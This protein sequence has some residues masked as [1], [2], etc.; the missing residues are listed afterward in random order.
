MIIRR[1]LVFILITPLFFIDILMTGIDI[2]AG[3]KPMYF[4]MTQDIEALYDG[5]PQ[6]LYIPEDG[7][8]R[9][10]VMRILADA[11]NMIQENEG[12]VLRPH[13]K[14]TDYKRYYPHVSEFLK[15]NQV[16][17]NSSQMYDVLSRAMLYAIPIGT[18]VKFGDVPPLPGDDWTKQQ[19]YW[20]SQMDPYLTS[21]FVPYS[22]D[23]YLMI[24]TPG[25]FDVH[26][27]FEP[28]DDF[29]D[30]VALQGQIPTPRKKGSKLKSNKK[31]KLVEA[32]YTWKETV[33]FDSLSK[34]EKKTVGKKNSDDT[35]VDRGQYAYLYSQSKSYG[36]ID[37]AYK[38]IVYVYRDN[39]FY[40][41]QAYRTFPNRDEWTKKIYKE[42]LQ[43][44]MDSYVYDRQNVIEV[45][46]HGRYTW[47]NQ[48][49][50]DHKDTSP[51]YKDRFKG[52]EDGVSFSVNI[53]IAD[54]ETFDLLSD[55]TE[56]EIDEWDDGSSSVV[57]NQFVTMRVLWEDY[58]QNNIDLIYDPNK[59]YTTLE[60]Y[61]EDVRY[62]L[63]SR[64][65]MPASYEM[66]RAL[67]D[68]ILN[69]T[70]GFEVGDTAISYYLP[71]G[72]YDN[73]HPEFFPEDWD[74]L[75]SEFG[76]V[77]KL[78]LFQYIFGN[79]IVQIVFWGVMLIS[80]ALCIGFS[81][82]A[83]MRSMGDF[84]LQKPVGRVF[85][86]ICKSM[87]TFLI[88][89]FFCIAT[90]QV[91]TAVLIQTTHI[92]ETAS[93]G[94]TSLSG[95]MF[96]T[97][98]RPRAVMMPSEKHP[99]VAFYVDQKGDLRQRTINAG[100]SARQE[101]FDTL[102]KEYTS[103]KKKVSLSTQ[104]QIFKDF[105][106][107]YAYHGDLFLVSIAAWFFLI[108]LALT[109]LIFLRRV[110]DVVTLYI[111]APLFVATIPL[112]DGQVFKRWREMF[113]GAAI[114]GFGSLITFKLFLLLMP[115]IFSPNLILDSNSAVDF[116]LKLLIMLGGMYAV[117]KMHSM[118]SQIA[119]PH[120]GQ[121]EA[122]GLMAGAAVLSF[123]KNAALA[124]STGGGSTA[125]Q[126]AKKK[127]LEAGKDKLSGGGD[128]KSSGN[129]NPDESGGSGG[130]G[131]ASESGGLPG[132]GGDDK[133]SG[134]DS[135]KNPNADSG[136]GGGLG[137][138]AGGGDSG[139]S[140]GD[141]NKQ[142]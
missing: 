46:D 3:V 44:I 76:G 77:N 16:P 75:G 126:A 138:G 45:R 93:G 59:S 36:V 78:T 25:V 65:I 101:R 107:F 28:I 102:Y 68:G 13:L 133:K 24:E 82:Y 142:E 20:T 106:W 139:D 89:P 43:R 87:L 91:S 62:F 17:L 118:I 94:G 119:N 99:T 64:G 108:M 124:A 61:T 96:M 58:V 132:M 2:F 32:T 92:I 18:D 121:N 70:L 105:D 69:D 115:L 95:S 33:R 122:S 86:L 130:G 4:A 71:A 123:A 56:S 51:P 109:T 31:Y 104:H 8:K 57:I 81:I 90:I 114:T 128:D 5:T 39:V 50:I 66:Y 100:E 83:V 97:A 67:A 135:N 98:M 136:G 125:A 74:A 26:G 117:Y 22:D 134:D 15:A 141:S 127:A 9:A 110:F 54:D 40:G 88:V 129:K 60:R 111:I 55:M 30:T 14:E 35:L 11:R 48:Y 84:S 140:G 7:T 1:I 6:I 52:F 37:E 49:L 116:F 137:V 47:A 42:E 131:G 23:Y 103:G 19:L 79:P 12:I 53:S 73:F 72:Y 21:I 112:D 63:S 10:M 120:A 113:I 29:E 27:V 34:S 85:G 41:L 38:K 80:M